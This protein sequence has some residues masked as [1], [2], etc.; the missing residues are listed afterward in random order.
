MPMAKS[1]VTGL[2]IKVYEVQTDG[3]KF[4]NKFFPHPYQMWTSSGYKTLYLYANRNQPQWVFDNP[5]AHAINSARAEID[6]GLKQSSQLA[7]AWAEREK[8]L[9]MIASA[10]ENLIEVARQVRRRDPALLRKIKRYYKDRNRNIQLA[11]D[12]SGLWL[13]YYFGWKPLISD[14][15]VASKVFSESL[16]AQNYTGKGYG[17]MS[18]DTSPMFDRN[19]YYEGF[20]FEY[21]VSVK[22]G[23]TAVV[24]DSAPIIFSRFGV[25]DPLSFFWELMPFSWAV[26][27]VFNVGQL[28]SNM[29]PQFPGISVKN[30]YTTISYHGSW[31]YGY[32]DGPEPLIWFT[33]RNEQHILNGGP[34]SGVNRRM[35]ISSYM[36]EFKLPD[37]SLQHVSYLCAVFVQL[38]GSSAKR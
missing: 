17:S 9:S 26:D 24:N 7:V 15:Q 21:F 5:P 2:H 6:Q 28:L 30:G 20:R 14:I 10:V 35:G 38:M 22:M 1:V 33:R 8:S 27:Y 36:G 3:R 13:Q 25:T 16:P 23:C 32:Y 19:G 29:E 18:R 37:L 12:F 4:V 31:W 11:Q 34:C